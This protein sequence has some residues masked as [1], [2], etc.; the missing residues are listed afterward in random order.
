M[1]RINRKI[2][3]N[4]TKNRIH[5]SNASVTRLYLPRKLGGRGL[6][7]LEELRRRQ[8][9]NLRKYFTDQESILLKTISEMDTYSPL[10]LQDNALEQTLQVPKIKD[11]YDDWLAKPLHGKYPK[12]LSAG[13]PEEST[14]WLIYGTLFGET[15]GFMCAIQDEVIS[16]KN[17]RKH[18]LKE[19]IDDRCRICRSSSETIQH[20]TSGCTPMAHTEYLK[21]HNLTAGIL[22]QNLTCKLELNDAEV[23]YYNYI[24]HPV[25]ENNRYK[26]YWDIPIRTDKTVASNRPDI[27]LHD[28]TRKEAYFIDIGHPNDHNLEKTEREK[29]SKYF[30]LCEEYKAI[31][32]LTKVSVIPVIITA[33]GIVSKNIWK[34]LNMIHMGDKYMLRTMQKSVILETCR[35]VRK[36]LNI[37]D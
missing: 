37:Q 27:V 17:Y 8:I 4:M 15:E 10:K 1:E 14:S 16:T 25:L 35:I 28:K 34:Y 7:N 30:E 6:L 24:P 26:V 5:H 22:H 13:H 20:I 19:N 3:T 2:R 31:H 32:K 33:T 11:K 9:L 18:I 36:C 21:R 23:P 29:V 12:S